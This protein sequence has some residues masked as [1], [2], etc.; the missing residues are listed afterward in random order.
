MA[1]L[2]LMAD[3]EQ[4][5]CLASHGEPQRYGMLGRVARG[6][7]MLGKSMTDI[8][9]ELLFGVI[10]HRLG[11]IT[12]PKLARAAE[13]RFH[14]PKSPTPLPQ[15]LIETRVISAEEGLFLG[16]LVDAA[17]DSSG[18]DARRVLE[19]IGGSDPLGEAFANTIVLSDDAEGPTI[20]IVARRGPDEATG[21]DS[22]IRASKEE[23]GRYQT[24]REYARGGMGRVMLVHDSF[25]GRDIALKELLPDLS[26][27]GHISP[28]NVA[29]FL[30][31]A[32]ITGR[33][34]H[35]SIVPVHE[36]GF[37]DDGTLYYTMKLVRGRTLRQAIATSK[38]LVDRLK[39]LPHYVDLCNALAYA[40]SR[41]IIHRDIKPSNVMVGEFGET[42]VLDW[43]L[44]KAHD[45]SDAHGEGVR[46]AIE[47]LREF[48]QE[49][50]EKTVY[51]TALGTPAYMA[52]EQA[53]GRIDAIG[54][55]SDVYSLGAVLYE[56][57]TGHAPFG[58]T[59]VRNILLSVISE[60]PTPIAVL[61]PHAPLEL[62][63]ICNHAMQKDPAA[64]YP[65]AKALAEDIQ[66]FQAGALVQAHEYRF[67]EH[68]SRFLH[69]HR[70]LVFTTALATTALFVL[71]IYS[72]I[73]IVYQSHLKDLAA[74]EAV[75]RAAE[76]KDAQNRAEV[77]TAKARSAEAS[78]VSEKSRADRE[79]YFTSLRLARTQIDQ[80]HYD[81]AKQTLLTSPEV[82]RNW[83][84]GRLQYLCN[85]DTASYTRRSELRPSGVEYLP[86]GFNIEHN[87]L[88]G[89]ATQGGVDLIDL[90][91]G[92]VLHRFP[93]D[94]EPRIVRA[95]I[96]PGGK[97]VAVLDDLLGTVYRISDYE[98]VLSFDGLIDWTW[99][100]G[101]SDDDTLFAARSPAD[102]AIHCYALGSSA[103]PTALTAISGARIALGPDGRFLLSVEEQQAGSGT[104]KSLWRVWDTTGGAPIAENTGKPI[105]SFGFLDTG[106]LVFTET[107]TTLSVWRF[108]GGQRVREFESG[109]SPFTCAY[110]NPK[111]MEIVTGNSSGEIA[112]WDVRQGRR[113][114]SLRGHVGAVQCIDRATEPRWVVSGGTDS[115]VRL[116]DLRAGQCVKTLLGHSTPVEQVRIS[117]SG[118]RIASIAGSEFKIWDTGSAGD[119]TIYAGGP[120]LA[121]G[122]TH[123]GDKFYSCNARG[124][125]SCRSAQ[126][127]RID[128]EYQFGVSDQ[129]APALSGDCEF[130]L[131]R[132]RSGVS[133]WSV[134]GRTILFEINGA[135]YTRVQASFSPDGNWLVLLDTTPLVAK[136]LIRLV[137][138]ETGEE[139]ASIAPL[140]AADAES[141]EDSGIAF[142][143]DGKRI[144][145][146]AEGVLAFFDIE[147]CAPTGSVS[148]G[149][150]GA[151]Q[152]KLCAISP[153]GAWA[154]F[155]EADAALRIVDIATGKSI[156]E[157]RSAGG[158]LTCVV[159]NNDGT[160]ALAGYQDGAIRGF[161]TQTGREVY[162]NRNFDSPVQYVFMSDTNRLLVAASQNGDVSVEYAYP[163]K[164][165]DYPGSS[166]AVSEYHL[167]AYKRHVQSASTSWGKCQAMLAAINDAKIRWAIAKGYDGQ[168]AT[169][170]DPAYFEWKTGSFVCP[171][172]GVYTAGS[173]DEV[174]RCSIHGSLASEYEIL[175]TIRRL[176]QAPAP[177]Q[178][179]VA[180]ALAA[181][182]PDD[183]AVLA[184]RLKEWTRSERSNYRAALIVGEKLLTL[185]GDRETTCEMLGE[186][187]FALKNFDRA[188]E[189]FISALKAGNTR[190]RSK[191]ALAFAKKGD[192][193]GAYEQLEAFL[194]D[195]PKDNSVS[196]A[197]A[198]LTPHREAVDAA[199]ADRVA[200]LASY[201]GEEWRSLHWHADLDEAI[202]SA[203]RENKLVFLF[204]QSPS[205]PDVERIRR[206]T[207][208][209]PDVREGLQS[210]YELCDIDASIASAT[211][212]RYGI[213]SL[214]S[215]L[216]L[217][218][219]GEPIST[220]DSSISIASI[221]KDFLKPLK[222]DGYLEDW[223]VI[224]PFDLDQGRGFDTVYPPE[225]QVDVN[226]MYDGKSGKVGW[227]KCRASELSHALSLRP[228]F[229]DLTS[230]VMYAYSEFEAGTKTGI[231][232]KVGSDDGCKVWVNGEWI[233]ERHAD[234]MRHP[235]AYHKDGDVYAMDLKTGRNT[236]L[237]KLM[238]YTGSAM[239]SVRV[240]EGDS[241]LAG[242]RPLPLPACTELLVSDPF[243]AAA[244]GDTRTQI[245]S[246]N[247]KGVVR[248]NVAW[249]EI[250]PLWR[251]SWLRIATDVRA[252]PFTDAQGRT[253]ITGE[254][255]GKQ[256]LLRRL[257][258]QDGDVIL[259][260]NGLYYDDI[261]LRP[262]GMSEL[263][264]RLATEKEWQVE[265]LRDGKVITHLYERK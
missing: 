265:I 204:V 103:T 165:N 9:K 49:A 168:A 56:L 191:L 27:P 53:E 173:W 21:A 255:L 193:N 12:P 98:R 77:A 28:S 186:A 50:L 240:Q 52:P 209:H 207:F 57:L 138:L 22:T 202:G 68:L 20:K 222:A 81:L 177:E 155:K 2:C 55:R 23:P 234:T 206:T 135:D 86:M 60:E 161:D 154:A 114:L 82:Y 54:E 130:L 61:E 219:R 48:G 162:T 88:A 109:E 123:R 230:T 223:L 99:T 134:V 172:D 65:T 166:P 78:A 39:F 67:R 247:G 197:L 29:R 13:V 216:V 32:R 158:E 94:S 47:A 80:G 214:P 217:N 245:A 147:S 79:L 264:N 76:A 224:G 251:D 5:V 262:E 208:S 148:L 150:P 160:R 127:G 163:W 187:E 241:P 69:K 145:I 64:R 125:V 167:E 126:S 137:N 115:T 199:L 151:G 257:G 25:L 44:A 40:H 72:Y 19:L 242:F 75:Q 92:Q 93:T 17:L 182:L 196:D 133:V 41:G 59:A 175:T 159:F 156:S 250:R 97:Y 104:Q 10:A 146:S 236:I 108:P 129:V 83:E 232:L 91:S 70:S 212:S 46:I 218:R 51:G 188:V 149:F 226:G 38:T 144:A 95:S 189:R 113:L 35:P 253:G 152:S 37:R 62:I 143:P 233:N 118:D 181:M 6:I 131:C 26:A 210:S 252:H 15:W 4:F 243:Y 63:A 33:L 248:F 256:P 220:P 179:L 174:P 176:E 3:C 107:D 171:Q 228:L 7:D 16:Q 184:D 244:V 185:K 192:V 141:Y 170:P 157:I 18:G 71:G 84:W 231:W 85:L 128:W 194:E 101:F 8:G 201:S 100:M 132:T 120:I 66:R 263:S 31:E 238:N 117:S 110:A 140:F 215:V 246:D 221:R 136:P 139:H 258:L 30:Q 14:N 121:G 213:S 260:A 106:N 142:T 169:L 195:Y 249:D 89:A 43:G 90:R 124:Y 45:H 111:G 58:G 229:G 180:R 122:Y 198:I 183:K 235:R 102:L 153:Q 211:V 254:N 227:K 24:V 87:L 42:V 239:F 164:S 116:W 205:S 73:S 178:S 96:S 225:S 105:R 74:A 34:E 1:S 261:L 190:V 237:L 36:I 259:S 119:A 11:R 200:A 112:V 203:A